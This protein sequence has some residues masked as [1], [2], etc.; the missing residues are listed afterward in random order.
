MENN[1]NE[2]QHPNIEKH[3]KQDFQVE[4]LAFFRINNVFHFI[5]VCN[6]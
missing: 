3:P 5:L 1:S 6:G 2:E 4:R